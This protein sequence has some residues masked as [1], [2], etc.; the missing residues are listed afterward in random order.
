MFCFATFNSLRYVND[1]LPA[2][3]RRQSKVIALRHKKHAE[4]FGYSFRAYV[5]WGDTFDGFMRYDDSLLADG[6]GPDLSFGAYQGCIGSIGAQCMGS[7]N[8]DT[9]CH[10]SCV[11]QN[12]WQCNQ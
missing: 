9:A 4:K 7:C 5:F 11:S 10:A 1:Q 6:G 8:G 2:A 3:D 12:S